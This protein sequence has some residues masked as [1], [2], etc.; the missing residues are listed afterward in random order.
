MGDIRKLQSILNSKSKSSGNDN[1]NET[2]EPEAYSWQA[3]EELPIN[4]DVGQDALFHSIFTCP[5]SREQATESNPPML[6]T[7]GH[8]LC[9]N[10]M[11]LIARGRSRFKCPY[12][13]HEIFGRDVVE[14]RI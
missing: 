3:L 10:S 1:A 14:L 9:K 7:C 8:A 12:C 11:L 5:V 2:H 13:P 4:I 6:L